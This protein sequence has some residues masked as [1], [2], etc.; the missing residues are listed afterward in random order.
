MVLGVEGLLAAF[1]RARIAKKPP[2][3]GC[4]FAYAIGPNGWRSSQSFRSYD[5]PRACTNAPVGRA[6]GQLANAYRRFSLSPG[7]YLV[8]E[9]P[10]AMPRLLRRVGTAEK[11]SEIYLSLET[12]E[13]LVLRFYGPGGPVRR[14]FLS[15]FSHNW[16]TSARTRCRDE[17]KRE[18][19]RVRTHTHTHTLGGG[20][21]SLATTRSL[22]R[23]P[24]VT[25]GRDGNTRSAEIP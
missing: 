24:P 23:L 25:G 4:L 6:S 18:K 16:R 7:R 15:L 2:S 21:L 9:T 5:R 12:N 20:L 19:E 17:E 22:S 8:K 3:P 10:I 11:A 14:F 13:R 1:E